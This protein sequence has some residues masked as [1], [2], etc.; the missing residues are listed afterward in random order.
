MGCVGA[1]CTHDPEGAGALMIKKKVCSKC[2][3]IKELDEF[4][5]HKK[6][7]DKHY[8]YCRKCDNESST[9]Y[10]RAHGNLAMSENKKCSAYLGVAIAER[11]ISHLFNDVQRMPF[12]HAGYDFICAKDKKID[13]KS[14]CITLNHKKNPHWEFN[15]NKNIIADYFL[16]LAFNNRDDLEPLHQWLMSGDK[17]NHMRKTT[18]SPSTIDK[19]DEWKQPIGPAL[20]CCNE[21]KGE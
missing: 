5:K 14:A 11:L 16:L 13:V 20:A 4:N 9:K 12:G 18:I 21:M 19:W 8:P 1:S 3:E 7:R 6:T 15:I 2:G 10:N 17:L